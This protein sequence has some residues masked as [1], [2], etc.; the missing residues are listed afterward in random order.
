M[1]EIN[2]S[3]LFK[4]IEQYKEAKI[5]S[6]PDLF[7]SGSV[8][9]L[10]EGGLRTKDCFKVGEKIKE[11]SF[12]G[13]LDQ[14]VV[15]SDD[16][17]RNNNLLFENLK[18]K[19]KISAVST[20]PLVTVITVVF[21][22]EDFLEE[23]ILSVLNQTYDNV[24][25]IIID[26]GSTDRSVEII[27]KY[28][29]KIDFWVSEK[30]HGIYDAMNKGIRSA[31][32]DIIGLLNADD[33]YD[34]TTIEKIVQSYLETKADVFFGKKLMLDQ[35]LQL[36]KEIS[37]DMP[38]SAKDLNIHSVHSTVFVKR[39]VYTKI[40]F[41]TCYKIS[42][43]YEFLLRVFE[44]NFQIKKIDDILTIMR[45]GGVS[46]TFNLEVFKIKLKKFGFLTASIYL[47]KRLFRGILSKTLKLF[48]RNPE[49]LKKYYLN[50]GW[51]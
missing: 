49:S 5:Q 22:G 20:K 19:S 9:R 25:Y 38:S 43:D 46:A 51:Q 11:Y 33:F 21:N 18:L 28:D 8:S 23:T 29:S 45:V 32:G 40:R 39:S 42:A 36:K 47:C 50:S 17:V 35:K 12:Y 27:K 4:I 14:F 44:E 24:E 41:N 7:L 16:Q 31:T 34:L 1:I 2:S 26:G 30:D 10:G 13:Y 6:V 15:Q 37:V 3:D 48:Y